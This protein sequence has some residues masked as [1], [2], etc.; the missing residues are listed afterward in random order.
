MLIDLMC[1]A[2]EIKIQICNMLVLH[3]SLIQA[4]LEEVKRTLLNRSISP[5]FL[6]YLVHS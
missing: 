2:E 3:A 5:F 6:P 4:M 1:L